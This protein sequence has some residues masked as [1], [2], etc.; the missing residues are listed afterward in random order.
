MPIEN[1]RRYAVETQVILDR[2]DMIIQ[3]NLDN[4]G[5]KSIRISLFNNNRLVDSIEL[6][7][8]QL[9][10]IYKIYSVHFDDIVNDIDK[11]QQALDRIN[12]G[13]TIW[14]KSEDDKSSDTY[15]AEQVLPDTEDVKLIQ[16][17]I[18]MVSKKWGE[19]EYE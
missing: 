4:L 2:D 6:T 12:Y 8:E 19:N 7:A 5:E 3:S 17:L 13:N 15:W 16:E 18:N 10:F 11:Y 1:I 9:R 14:P